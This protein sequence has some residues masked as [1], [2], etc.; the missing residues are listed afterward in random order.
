MYH[1]EAD[2]ED[3]LV[4]AGEAVLIIEG[5]ERRCGSGTSST[6]RRTRAHDRRRRPA[7]SSSPSARAS[8]TARPDWG[9]YPV[10]ETAA[11]YGAS[12]RVETT[13]PSEAYAHLTRRRRPLSRRL[14]RLNRLPEAVVSRG[15]P[16]G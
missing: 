8:T 10:D 9:G 7:P 1:W 11:R 3:F 2:Q 16:S 14:A 12:A 13:E 4:V 15:R 5:E 6:A